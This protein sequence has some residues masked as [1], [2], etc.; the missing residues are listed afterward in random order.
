[1]AI[2][3]YLANPVSEVEA[4]RRTESAPS[5]SRLGKVMPWVVAALGIAAALA[6][7]FVHFRETPPERQHIRFQ[8]TPPEGTLLDFKLS[9][10]GRFLAFATTDGSAGKLWIRALDSLE[11]RLLTSVAPF[12]PYLFWSPGGE[13]VGF[14]ISGK[15]YKV[16]STGGP[17]VAVCDLL[18][19]FRGAAWRS[20]GT[21]LLAS[22]VGLYRVSSSGGTPSK[23]DGETTTTAVPMW[24]TAERFI[25][26]TPNGIFASSLA[27]KP[28]LLLPDV[29]NSGFVPPAKSGVPGHILFLRSGTLMAQPMDAG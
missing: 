6:V 21:V 11:T 8:L 24:L 16:A 20:D 23:V 28:S 25:F 7:G 22:A 14:A 15:I 26:S 4:P 9:P 1:V 5:P 29:S 10:D 27:G 3:R 13:Y 18:P 17:P 19:G 2:Q 12:G